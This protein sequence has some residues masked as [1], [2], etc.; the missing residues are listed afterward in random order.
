MS[1]PATYRTKD[2]VSAYKEERDPIAN[3]KIKMQAAGIDEATIKAI[4]KDIK[5]IVNEA[6]DFSQSSPEPAEK[7][8]W[9]NVLVEVQG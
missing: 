3:L 9:T 8:L 7:E 6:A 5:A 4:D 2:E 1:D